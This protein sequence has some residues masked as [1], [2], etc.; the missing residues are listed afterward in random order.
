MQRFVDM[1]SNGL[2][3]VEDWL[4][5]AGG[6]IVGFM[7][8]FTTSDVIARGVFH[9]PI[10]GSTE[11]TTLIFVFV[12]MLG[13][14][15]ALRRGEHLAMGVVFDRLP[16]KVQ[17]IVLLVNISLGLFI[18]FMLTWSSIDNTLWAYGAGDTMVG[19]IP[20]KTWW[21]RMALPIGIGLA[22]PRLIVQMVQVA[23]G[24]V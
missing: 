3:K 2:A 5:L 9:Q 11:Y 21:A 12:V 10:K 17:R 19:A 16:P 4:A 8:V 23:R 1:F 7:M 14:S 24:E 22:F 13:I 20:V 15:Y 6:L 18:V